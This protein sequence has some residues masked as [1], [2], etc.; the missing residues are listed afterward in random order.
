MQCTDIDNKCGG[1]NEGTQK[2]V[3]AYATKMQGALGS[4][5]NV[6]LCE[7]WFKTAS[8]DEQRKQ[9]DGQPKEKMA[10]VWLEVSDLTHLKINANW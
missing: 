3:A 10:M 8:P 9:W 7:P 5:Y 2:L 4:Y 1:L 6:V